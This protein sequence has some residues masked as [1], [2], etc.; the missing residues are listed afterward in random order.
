[1][2]ERQPRSFF[3][4]TTG[5][6]VHPLANRY[7]IRHDYCRYRWYRLRIKFTRLVVKDS[8]AHAVIGGY[9]IFAKILMRWEVKRKV[10]LQ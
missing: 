5:G 8:I 6:R 2:V 10:N 9:L 3:V 1:M 4:T 7:F